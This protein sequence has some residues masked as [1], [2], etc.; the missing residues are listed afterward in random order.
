MADMKSIFFINF[1]ENTHFANQ[2]QNLTKKYVNVTIY[3]LPYNNP[4]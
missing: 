4:T 2:L 1:C 3:Y